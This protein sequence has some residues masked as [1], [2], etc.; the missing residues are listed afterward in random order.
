MRDI[1][2]EARHT[3]S[4]TAVALIL[5]KEFEQELLKFTVIFDEVCKLINKCQSDKC[6]AFVTVNIHRVSSYFIYNASF[7]KK[8]F[9]NLYNL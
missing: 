9:F 6:N 8:G 3:I 4:E 1:V 2:H 7:S 5:D